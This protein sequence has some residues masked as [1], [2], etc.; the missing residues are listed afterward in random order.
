VGYVR[1]AM[2]KHTTDA[3]HALAAQSL[4]RVGSHTG[5]MTVSDSA[6]T[7]IQA[8]LDELAGAVSQMGEGVKDV[9]THKFAPSQIQSLTA[10]VSRL[11]HVMRTMDAA[12]Y[13]DK[14]EG[15]AGECCFALLGRSF[16]G[17]DNEDMLLNH[18][19]SVC[20]HRLV[21]RFKDLSVLRDDQSVLERGVV[22]VA[23]LR[24]DF[25]SR[26]EEI[27]ADADHALH[28]IRGTAYWAV[29]RVLWLFHS[30]SASDSMLDMHTGSVG[31]QPTLTRFVELEIQAA[32]QRLATAQHTEQQ[33]GSEGDFDVPAKKARRSKQ[34][35]GKKG[36]P[37]AEGDEDKP[38]ASSAV[39]EL[40]IAQMDALLSVV[41]THIGS[42]LFG[43]MNMAHGAL[44]FCKFEC[45]GAVYDDLARTLLD[46]IKQKLQ[47]HQRDAVLSVMMASLR[48]SFDDAMDQQHRAT[49]PA[50]MFNQ[51]FALA[52]AFGHAV[53][54]IITSIPEGRAQLRN[55]SEISASLVRMHGDGIGYAATKIAGYAKLENEA[56][57]EAMVHWFRVLSVMTTGMLAPKHASNILS[58][59]KA[60]V[61]E[62]GVQVTEDK[63]WEAYRSYVKKL[64]QV[65]DAAQEATFATPARTEVPPTSPG[66]PTAAGHGQAKRALA[67]E[68][69]GAEH[70]SEAAKR[71]RVEDEDEQ[72]SDDG[73]SHQ[74]DEYAM[75]DALMLEAEALDEF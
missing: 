27:I 53:R 48:K 21:W 41:G 55:A 30:Q 62:E 64:Q 19:M 22:H 58:R 16:L 35:T 63:T 20:F 45:F 6:A 68:G 28:S 66:T 52:R 8:L 1:G 70:R 69:H 13:L 56:A 3:V 37:K 73:T 10:A 47:T 67:D 11:S 59:L 44:V 2:L 26:C 32:A 65:V 14:E 50:T 33:S 23:K 34:K 60:A 18:A 61:E 71:V 5:L 74:Q 38:Q 46:A 51:T 24:D 25:Y 43:T 42:I 40:P 7:A 49:N 54:S 9:A 39:A 72:H 12:K 31:M 36:K 17:K 4:Q 57:V 15:G 29:S 75:H